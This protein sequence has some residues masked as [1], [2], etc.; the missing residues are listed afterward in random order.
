MKQKQIHE[1][2]S[3]PGNLSTTW[4]AQRKILSMIR[5]IRDHVA[6][7]LINCSLFQKVYKQLFSKNRSM[8]FLNKIKVRNMV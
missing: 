3:R 1:E 8:D 5:Q 7:H 4:S 2:V 6:N